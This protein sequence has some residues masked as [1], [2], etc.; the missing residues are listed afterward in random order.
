MHFNM[1]HHQ[2][3]PNYKSEVGWNRNYIASS[4]TYLFE[5]CYGVDNEGVYTKE[6]SIFIPA[7]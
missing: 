4:I 3:I 6:N 2:S 1:N 7:L 5:Q